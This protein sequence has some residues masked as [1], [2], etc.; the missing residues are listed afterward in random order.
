MTDLELRITQY[1]L[2]GGLFNPEC[3]DHNEVRELLLDC[4]AALTASKSIPP[5]SQ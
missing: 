3:M 4:L 1:L 5:A 2:H